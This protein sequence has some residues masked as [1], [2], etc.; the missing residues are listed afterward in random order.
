MLILGGSGV[1]GSIAVPLAIG[2][3][4]TV[5]ATAGGS[6][7][8]YVASLGPLPAA[9]ERAWRGEFGIPEAVR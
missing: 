6:S 3:G 5:I 7:A 1:V 9:A 2:R 4:A 8:D